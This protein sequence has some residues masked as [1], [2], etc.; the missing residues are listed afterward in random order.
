MRPRNRCA[1]FPGPT[2][3]AGALHRNRQRLRSH[4]AQVELRASQIV[5]FERVEGVVSADGIL[6]K[7][8]RKSAFPHFHRSRQHQASDAGEG[9]VA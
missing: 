7:F 1:L 4:L 8:A 5:R 3:V 9:S 6:E 2:S